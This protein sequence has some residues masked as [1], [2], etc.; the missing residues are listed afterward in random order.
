MPIRKLIEINGKH[1]GWLE[2]D[3][4]KTMRVA[5]D[6]KKWLSTINPENDPFG[7]LKYDLPLVDSALEKKLKLP[8]DGA[9]PHAR[10]LGEGLLPRE[11]TKISAPFYN[12]IFGDMYE[13]PKVITIDNRYY[14][15]VDFED[16]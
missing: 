1:G 8:Y 11:Y 9:R 6:F 5:K 16:P 14:A 3:P 15:W 7:F 13:T 10:A 12:T 2:I 4:A